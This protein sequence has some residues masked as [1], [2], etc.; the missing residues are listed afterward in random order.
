MNIVYCKVISYADSGFYNLTTYDLILA[1]CMAARDKKYAPPR[2]AEKLLQWYCPAESLE[3]V[4]GDLQ[5]LF[6]YWVET[7]G[8]AE[9]D[10][11]YIWCTFRLVRPFP[12]LPAPRQRITIWL[13]AQYR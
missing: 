9:A 2:W 7:H 3:E 8:K 13:S 4:Q 10:R 1:L 6:M 12:G 5:E 11:Y